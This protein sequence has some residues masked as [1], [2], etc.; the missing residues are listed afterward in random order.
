VAAD[1]HAE[2]VIAPGVAV[3]DDAGVADELVHGP[4][5][6]HESFELGLQHTERHC[7]FEA[8]RAGCTDDVAHELELIGGHWLCPRGV[9]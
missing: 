7:P 8:D 2:Q 4:V 5:I 3:P 1:H 9:G 6:G